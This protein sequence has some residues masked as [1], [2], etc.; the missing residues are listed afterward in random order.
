MMKRLIDID[1]N[2]FKLTT[3]VK[4]LPGTKHLMYLDNITV[5]NLFSSQSGSMHEQ[6]ARNKSMI[7]TFNRLAKFSHLFAHFKTSND[8]LFS[9][10]FIFICFFLLLTVY[11]KTKSASLIVDELIARNP[12]QIK[13]KMKKST[14]CYHTTI[15]LM[16][17][18]EFYGS[19]TTEDE[20]KLASCAKVVHFLAILSARMRNVSKLQDLM[21][22]SLYENELQ[23]TKHYLTSLTSCY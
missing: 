11:S 6:D 13:L 14:M 21:D 2:A 3:R 17:F 1:P 9:I 22:Y 19:E 7:Q 23:N 12:E 4:R 10:C 20:S 16:Y 15:S 18:T 5:M 8:F